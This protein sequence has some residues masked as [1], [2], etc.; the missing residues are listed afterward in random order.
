MSLLQYKN[1]NDIL[2]TPKQYYGDRY[3]E[4][5]NNHL[6]NIEMFSNFGNNSN[7]ALELHIYN[8]V[9][10]EYIKSN[11]NILAYSISNLSPSFQDRPTIILNTQQDLLNLNL[12]NGKYKIVYNF[13]RN[14]LGG[15]NIINQYL[16]IEDISPNRT[17]LRVYPAI[18][19]DK[20]YTDKIIQFA[21]IRKNLYNYW[22]DV[23]M[24]FSKNI[25]IPV[26]NWQLDD[27]TTPEYPYSLLLKLYEPLPDTIKEKDL[28]WITEEVANPLIDYV[29]LQV[30]TITPPS[31]LV[32]LKNANFNLDITQ[33]VGYETEY[34]SW[35]D[36]LGLNPLSSQQLVNTYLNNYSGSISA[37]DLNVDYSNYN[38]FVHFSS[39]AERLNNFQYKVELIEYYD[40]LI[41]SSSILSG[42]NTSV[43][44]SLILQYSDKKNNI[45]SSF[46]GFEK[47]M[48]YE[49]GSSFIDSYGV[50]LDRTWPKMNST[51]PYILYPTTSSIAQT[52]FINEMQSAILYDRNN[53]NALVES[54]PAHIRSKE[55]SDGL[56]T[57]ESYM[58]FINMIA[59][60]FDILWLYIDNLTESY[61]KNQK[62]TQGIAKDLIYYFVESFGWDLDDGITVDNLWES[63]LGISDEGTYITGSNGLEY[64]TPQNRQKEIW[65][66]I[67]NNLP[68]LLKQKGTARGIKALI[69]C[70]GVPS[71]ILRIKEYGGTTYNNSEYEIDKYTNALIFT[72]SQYITVPKI[73]NTKTIQF[74][75][76]PYSGSNMPVKQ[77][78][79]SGSTYSIGL[80]YVE[81]VYGRLYNTTIYSS[82]LLPI[83]DGNWWN[84]MLTSGSN[85]STLYA[86]RFNNDRFTYQ[87]SQSFNV[88]ITSSISYI[89]SNANGFSY[90]TGSLQEFRIWDTVLSEYEFQA[91]CKN[92][93]AYFTQNPTASYDALKLRYTF[94]NPNVYNG[95]S[96]T[97]I[98]DYNPTEIVN[99]GTA[100]I[101]LTTASFESFIENRHIKTPKYWGNKINSDK[102][103]IQSGSLLGNL[104]FKKKNEYISDTRAFDSPKLGINFSPIDMINED[105]FAQ[106]GDFVLDNYIGNPLN[107]FKSSYIE[108]DKLREFY[109]KKYPKPNNFYDYVEYIKLY[110]KSLFK[111]IKKLLPERNNS[112]VGL[113][114]ESHILERPKYQ[115][116]PM[117]ITSE[118]KEDTIDY[119]VI[120]SGDVVDLNVINNEYLSLF[121]INSNN[122]GIST[123]NT[124]S[125][126][127]FNTNASEISMFGQV[128]NNK[129]FMMN[130]D[131]INLNANIYKQNYNLYGTPNLSL[132]N[133]IDIW[134]YYSSSVGFGAIIDTPRPSAF[135]TKLERFNE[136]RLLYYTNIDKHHNQYYIPNKIVKG[137]FLADVGIGY[138]PADYVNR[139]FINTTDLNNNNNYKMFQNYLN[140]PTDTSIKRYLHVNKTIQNSINNE[141]N[142]HNTALY[143]ITGPATMSYTTANYL[144]YTISSF[145]DNNTVVLTSLFGDISSQFSIGDI[146]DL[147][148]VSYELQNLKL[149]VSQSYYKSPNT[150]VS[151]YE[152]VSGATTQVLINKTTSAGRSISADHFIGGATGIYS[153]NI[154]ELPVTFSAYYADSFT[155]PIDSAIND[156]LSS[157]YELYFYSIHEIKGDIYF[158]YY[159]NKKY[160]GFINTRYTTIDKKEPVEVFKAI[161]S[162]DTK[163]GDKLDNYT[164]NIEYV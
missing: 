46:D 104:D 112:I 91:Y 152:T 29:D 11:H 42:S 13:I 133:N 157:A 5:M 114:Y 90:Y 27:I 107:Q 124:E 74:R 40:M 7:D 39:A 141:L 70:Y 130:S 49:S 41:A 84:I 25:T 37:I 28:F 109:F 10:N 47:Y 115:W 82:S 23:I 105:I 64:I 57:N 59:Q 127:L 99:Y 154:I 131:Y 21:N 35:D 77:N 97:L 148:S 36:I 111:Q 151:F 71:T 54:I 65:K 94:A 142:I 147:S 73:D 160:T 98:Y 143:E 79:Y 118:S 101:A 9:T 146:C 134:Q 140:M 137:T 88:P 116:K 22:P 150:I 78:L 3:F 135:S 72:D 4:L 81:G 44:Q 12:P 120:G 162:V 139:F 158:N 83:F 159:D 14:I 51:K 153:N 123:T 75:F 145:I 38:N 108:L 56:F 100:S 128:E 20:T 117:S 16:Y 113:S 61:N 30:P 95:A 18:N 58:L 15:F 1:I 96:N 26:I 17:E 102:I 155:I 80:E 92:P 129:I 86:Y 60:H 125:L 34:K 156:I 132:N 144:G 110:D 85:A 76:K 126:N 33:K 48:Y 87:W 66:R 6:P 55:N 103:R 53:K 2:S 163:V 45:I 106:M 122:I 138:V 121:S 8:D 31:T 43:V 161:S 62:I 119:N 149:T 136:V 164:D 19:T 93:D 24:N 63:T 50:N 89:S 69:S 67:Y 32:N 68:N 52:W